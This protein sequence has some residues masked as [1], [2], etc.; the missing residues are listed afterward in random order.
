MFTTTARLQPVAGALLALAVILFGAPWATSQVALAQEQTLF[1]SVVDAN[2]V[3]VT[4]LGPE[5]IVVQWDEVACETVELEP[6][7][8]PVRVTVFVD[9]GDAAVRAIQHMREGLKGFMAAIPDDV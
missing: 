7:D 2:G 1:V 3:P 6:I 9:N 4:D 5:E 8:W